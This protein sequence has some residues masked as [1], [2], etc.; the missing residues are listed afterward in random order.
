MVAFLLLPSNVIYISYQECAD[1]PGAL[2]PCIARIIGML[3]IVKELQYC[4]PI[5]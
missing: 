4:H 3:L 2:D 5:I 1:M